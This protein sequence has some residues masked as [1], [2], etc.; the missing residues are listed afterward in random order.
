MYKTTGIG[1]SLFFIAVGAVWRGRLMET[2][3]NG[4]TKGIDW[5]MVG[6]IVFL[7]GVAGL[8]FTL[9]MTFAAHGGGRTRIIERSNA[10]PTRGRTLSVRARADR[11]AKRPG[12][13]FASATDGRL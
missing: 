10:E 3:T 11:H 4:G 8:L 6:L 12:R 2:A 1:T 9:V 5:N 7:I 13:T